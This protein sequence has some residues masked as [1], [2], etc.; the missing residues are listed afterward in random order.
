MHICMDAYSTMCMWMWMYA[1][2]YMHIFHYLPPAIVPNVAYVFNF[3]SLEST[4]CSIN[5]IIT[6]LLLLLYGAERVVTA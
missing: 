2:M 5:L 3:L 1:C 4:L 6:L